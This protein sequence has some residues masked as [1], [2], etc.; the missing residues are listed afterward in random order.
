V[1][2]GPRS[3]RASGARE[4]RRV[5]AVVFDV[6][7]TLVDETNMWTRVARAGGLTPFTLMAGLG[8]TI[9][10]GRP[11]DD[12]WELLDVEHPDGAWTMDDWY[13][14]ALP[15]IA[16]LR[17]AGY[18]VFAAGNTPELVERELAPHFDG[19][20]T[21]ARWGV[22]KP[23]PA[24]FERVAELADVPAAKIAYV[25]DRVDT[26]VL[27]A[28]AAGMVAVHIRRGPWGHLQSPPEDALRIRSLD[29]LPAALP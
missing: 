11:H 12:V 10:L 3:A 28:L 18:G 6:G 19:V 15:A 25:G 21:A 27:P 13:A 8:A 2:P 9:A 1:R 20:G 29:E 5:E 24:F 26:D 4:A 7:E 23:A 14:D 17:A 22:W 16:R